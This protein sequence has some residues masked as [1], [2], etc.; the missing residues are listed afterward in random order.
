MFGPI[1]GSSS[2]DS[3]ASISTRYCVKN[4]RSN[5]LA[6]ISFCF[7]FTY[8]WLRISFA[9]AAVVTMSQ[10][11]VVPNGSIPIPIG[12]RKKAAILITIILLDILQITFGG[13]SLPFIYRHSGYGRRGAW[14]RPWNEDGV[15]GMAI[16]NVRSSPFLRILSR[17]TT[18][19]RG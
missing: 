16:F 6:S 14:A 1:F 8:E 18:L 7:Y 19:F 12:P 2:P 5:I 13:L 11:P 4:R 17:L 10:Q 9:K 3:L 15:P